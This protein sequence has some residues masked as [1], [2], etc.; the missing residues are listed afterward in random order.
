MLR[1]KLQQ[2]FNVCVSLQCKAYSAHLEKL[3]FNCNKWIF[4]DL[5]KNV[6]GGDLCASLGYFFQLIAMIGNEFVSIFGLF[7]MTD[8]NG[9]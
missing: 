5:P 3:E 2:R 7:V 9:R 8:C 4:F 1:F 6:F